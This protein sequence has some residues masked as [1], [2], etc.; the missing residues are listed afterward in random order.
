[1]RDIYYDIK[2]HLGI[3]SYE[4]AISKFQSLARSAGISSSQIGY[5]GEI[6]DPSIS[7]I[8]VTIISK[9]YILRKVHQSFLAQCEADSDFQYCFY[10]PPVYI[11][12]RLADSIKYVHTLDY[13][14]TELFQNVELEY[15]NHN[16][17]D[18]EQYC[19]NLSWFLSLI[20]PSI[21]ILNGTER[22]LRRS[23]LL[24]KN[25]L[26]S[27]KFFSNDKILNTSEKA[28]QLREHLS[29]EVLPENL[30]N[31]I[32]TEISRILKLCLAQLEPSRHILNVDDCHTLS[33][34]LQTFLHTS[35]PA[36]DIKVS[37]G[38][39][40]RL[41]IQPSGMQTTH[42]LQLSPPVFLMMLLAKNRT[43]STS[44][45]IPYV[46]SMKQYIC[47]LRNIQA[48]YLRNLPFWYPV[49]PFDIFLPSRYS[50]IIAKTLYKLSL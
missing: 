14:R 47:R 49:S 18:S 36:F 1:M 44:S 45:H 32:R 38:R 43:I 50:R 39:E 8:D 37:L 19:L 34:K 4:N 31:I 10:H 46:C 7:D 5:F 22:S 27:Y 48:H 12:S 33:L 20:K 15:D 26:R 11:D 42:F 2:S 23:L 17:S 13:R 9:P 21:D 29:P 40:C 3:A 35:F 24:H 30:S 28:T 6:R 16:L 25:L 41:I